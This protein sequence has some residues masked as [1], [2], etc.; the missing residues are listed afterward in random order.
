M[1]LINHRSFTQIKLC[2]WTSLTSKSTDSPR[3]ARHS[4]VA[5]GSGGKMKWRI[6]YPSNTGLWS[7]RTSWPSLRVDRI[8]KVEARK[9]ILSRGIFSPSNWILKVK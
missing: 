7:I 6:K 8:P 5:S 9:P 3:H 4:Q 2:L 1:F